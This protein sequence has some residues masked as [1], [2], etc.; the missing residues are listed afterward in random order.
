MIKEIQAATGAVVDGDIGPQTMSDIACM[1]NAGCFPLT[2]KI[3]SM[4]VII[5]NDI[6]VAASPK[7]GLSAFTNS[8][9]GGFYANAVPCS[10]CVS[11]GVIKNSIACHGVQ[12]YPESVMYKLEDGTVGLKRVTN[13]SE[14]PDGVEW[15]VGAMGL[16]DN[17]DPDAEGFCKV[18]STGEDFS[19]VLRDTNHAALGYKN[20]YFYLVYCKSMTAAQVN[21]FAKTLGLELAIMLDGGHIAGINGTEDFAKINTSITQYYIVQGV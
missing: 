8:M 3:Y 9:N 21:A 12:G 15:A 13:A 16:L 18:E 11:D 5:A 1:L 20:G 10:I 4:P 19:D 6:V 2:L 7:A 14:L 17:Y